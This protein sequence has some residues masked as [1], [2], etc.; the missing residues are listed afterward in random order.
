MHPS[1]RPEYNSAQRKRQSSTNPLT[2]YSPERGEFKGKIHVGGSRRRSMTAFSQLVYRSRGFLT[3]M[4]RGL[5]VT[6]FLAAGNILE[7]HSDAV[8]P[9]VFG[10]SFAHLRRPQDADIAAAGRFL[11]D[12]IGVPMACV[13]NPSRDTIA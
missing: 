6:A 13:R 11:G 4:V 12:A 5:L 1:D 10:S 2:S 9:H 3:R 7:H 8:N